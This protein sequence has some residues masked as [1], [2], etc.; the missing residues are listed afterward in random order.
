MERD[1]GLQQRE[2]GVLGHALGQGR[3]DRMGRAQPTQRR[4]E[5]DASDRPQPLPERGVRDLRDDADDPRRTAR[6]RRARDV[7]GGRARHHSGQSVDEHVGIARAAR[8]ERGIVRSSRP[9]R[10]YRDESDLLRRRRTV[11]G[12]RSRD[13]DADGGT[14][15]D[16]DSSPGDSDRRADRYPSSGNGNRR[17]DPTDA[18][19]YAD[20]HR[21]DTDTGRTD[22]TR[23]PT[24]PGA[25]PTPSAADIPVYQDALASPWINASWS[26]TI[27]FANAS[28]VFSGTRSIKIAETGWGALS[29]HDGSWSATQPIDP[30]RYQSVQ[31]R[32]FTA[33]SFTVGVRLEN[34]AHAAFPEVVF[35][36]VP[37]NQWVLVTVPIAALD[38][39]G[40]AFDRVDIADHN[41][42]T[43]TYYVDELRLI[44][45]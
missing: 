18:D 6:E 44:G 29:L 32:L 42:V 22:A 12:Q 16:P 36:T 30:A 41:G 20:A 37:A 27:D 24:P 5:R 4:L 13:T 17:P 11:R 7:S 25:T 35:G 3:R 26:A 38:P 43:R 31:F 8:S 34:D 33:S 39:N 21:P 23:T 14:D 9:V 19:P 15:C 45:K 10:Q 2:P 1:R 40:V 28:P